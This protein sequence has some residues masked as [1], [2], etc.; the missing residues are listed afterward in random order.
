MFASWNQIASL[1]V[2]DRRALLRPRKNGFGLFHFPL[3]RCF[4]SS[5][6]CS[7]RTANRDRGERNT[8]ED[9]GGRRPCELRVREPRN[10]IVT[11]HDSDSDDASDLRNIV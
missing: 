10:T 6:Q 7:T 9:I 4:N 8:G 5:N 11:S 1:A 3:T 2:T